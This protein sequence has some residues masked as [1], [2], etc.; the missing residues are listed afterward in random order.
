VLPNRF[1]EADFVQEGNESRD[2]AKWS[3]GTSRLAQGQPL[4]RQQ[5]VDLA[6]DWFVPCV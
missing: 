5:G 1:H 3:H 6:R 4:I 2:P